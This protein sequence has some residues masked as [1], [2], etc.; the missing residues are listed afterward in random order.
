MTYNV[1]GGTL[2]P[3]QS[4]TVCTVYVCYHQRFQVI[5]P[6][7]RD[8]YEEVEILMRYDHPNIVKLRDVRGRSLFVIAYWLYSDAATWW[9]ALIQ[10]AITLNFSFYAVSDYCTGCL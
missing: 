3:T 5:E 9:R 7:K 8:P 6:Q 10:N 4:I 2:N 1:F